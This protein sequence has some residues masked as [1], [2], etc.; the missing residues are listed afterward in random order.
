MTSCPCTYFKG[1]IGK[2]G[3]KPTVACMRC[4]E[5]KLRCDRELLLCERCVK[6]KASCVYPSLP[7]RRRIAQRT[8]R[9]KAS[10]PPVSAGE[11]YRLE[12]ISLSFA[13]VQPPAN[14]PRLVEKTRD[15]ESPLHDC[16]WSDA[17]DLP[18]TEV[19]LLLLEVYFKRVYI[20]N[21]LFHMAIAFQLYMQDGIPD[22]LLRA[23]FAHAAVL[24]KK[25]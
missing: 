13:S 1:I 5:Q 18:S 10:P 4:R 19:G 11:A 22:C 6:Q 21:M 16:N 14:K 2:C 12:S 8:N 23:I 24:L 3:P 20:A 7:D 9:A 25:R 17:A 15:R